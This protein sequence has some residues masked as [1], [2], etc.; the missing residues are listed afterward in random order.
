MSTGETARQGKPP[1][2]WPWPSPPDPS[3]LSR[4][5]AQ[6]RSELKLTRQQV[7]AAAGMSPRYLEYLERYPA[8]MTRASLRLLAAALQ[9][10]PSA[11]LGAGADAPPGPGQAAP[12]PVVE[13]LLPAEC[14]RLL[15]PGGIGRVAF[16]TGGGTAVLPVN[17]AMVRDAV[18]FRTSEGTA[19]AAHADGE[20]AFEADHIDEANSQGWSVLVN[21]H[22]DRVRF[23]GDLRYLR[24]HAKITPWA[25][26]DREVY[27]RLTPGSISGRRIRASLTPGGGTT[28]N[29]GP[30]ENPGKSSASI[31]TDGAS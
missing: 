16:G 14:R 12:H 24:Q 28:M 7:A 29:P 6:R 25:G 23:P 17:F 18:V 2:G 11:L 9:T 19:L 20:M 8:C 30:A 31:R 10:T 4:R 15:A 5:V 21:G 26:G 13:K 27:I 22:A 3:D 1:V